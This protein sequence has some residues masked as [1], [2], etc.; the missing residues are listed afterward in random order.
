MLELYTPHSKQREIHNAINSGN[1]K[2]YIVSIGRQF[3]KTLLAENQTLYWAINNKECKIGW[4]SP[5]YSQ[6]KK[7]YG[8]IFKAI[9]NTP[10]ISDS[11]KSDLLL[12]FANGS[13]LQFF[14]AE[15]FDNIRGNTFAFAILFVYDNL[16]VK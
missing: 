1:Q 2:Y 6:C 11:N 4:V 12:Q 7:V 3:G 8:E 15:R 10:Y 13:T 5:V 9:A 14:S 16:A